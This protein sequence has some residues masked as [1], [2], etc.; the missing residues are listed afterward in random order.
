MD[1]IIQEGKTRDEALKTALEKLNL[2]QDEVEVE[3]LGTSKEGFLGIFGTKNIRIKVKR[4]NA[5]SAP[6]QPTHSYT[7]APD[8]RY[9]DDD[10]EDSL[11]QEQLN[12][13]DGEYV[14][15]KD[16]APIAIEDVPQLFDPGA[17]PEDQVYALV[18]RMLIL[19]GVHCR[20]TVHE[21]QSDIYVEISGKDAGIVIGK[22]G[23]TLESIQYIVNVVLG[24]K[25]DCKKKVVFDVGDYRE[26]REQSVRK[27]ARSVAKKV[28]KSR[29]SE[30]L[31]P[32]SP[33][34]R[35]IVHLALASYRNIK[36]VSE[37]TG[38]N[39]KVI[40]SFKD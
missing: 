38:Q 34:D 18:K 13:D 37:G 33:Q 24:K 6:P 36:T 25:V 1:E 22:F 39:R 7:P 19:M 17:T 5:P 23:Q 4:K 15:D 11:P 10:A 30:A 29:K 27:L 12:L 28:I 8:N 3:I 32:M 2:T 40:I 20:V 16:D 26:R 9:D 14:G 31:S 35:R 21:G